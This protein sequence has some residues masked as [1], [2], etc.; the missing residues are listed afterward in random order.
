M[1]RVYEA[2]EASSGRR[3]ALKV[4]PEDLAADP[5]FVRRFHREAKVLAALSHPHVVE[6]LEQGE[7]GGRLWFAMEYVRG[8]NLRRRVEGG[9]LPPTEAVRIAA[10]V[11][12]ALAYAHGQGVVHRDLKPENVLLDE[13]GRVRL[14]DFG[15]SR[16]RAPE[17]PEATTRLTRTDVILGTYEYMAPEQRRG[18]RD[19]DGRADLFALGVILYEMLT[20]TLPLGRFAPASEAAPGVPRAVDAVVNRALAPDRKDRHASAEDFRLA[21]L[22]AARSSDAPLP[23]TPP[24]PHDE[25]ARRVLR[26]VEIL[27]ALDRV[28]GILLLLS[29]FG[30]A[31]LFKVTLGGWLFRV[32]GLVLIVGSVVFFKLGRRL[33]EMAPRS[34]ENQV[35]ASIVLLFLPPLGTAMGIY[36][37]LVL[38]T[39]RARRA[40][41]LGRRAFL[42]PRVVVERPVVS[43]PP[44][45]RRERPGFLLHLHLLAACGWLLWVALIWLDVRV[46]TPSTGEDAARALITARTLSAVGLAFSLVVLAWAFGHRRARRGV[47]MALAATFLLAC[48]TAWTHAAVV[49]PLTLTP[50]EFLR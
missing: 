22:E 34:R 4:L 10:E 43:I 30:A 38:T 37:L 26:H 18:E 23:S 17:A 48:A 45:P 36:G 8:E 27:S 7:D 19:L 13:D 42:P 12:T 24:A 35:M 47:G 21:L 40:F 41:G 31:S 29:V 28:L 32:S 50:T 46:Q 49:V 1:G 5:S 2:R 39:D 25:D 6:V 20:G 9:P 3:V 44:A 16:L 33:G 14:V 11:A 15:L